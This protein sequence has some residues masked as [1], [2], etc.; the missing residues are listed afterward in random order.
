MLVRFPMQRSGDLPRLSERP[1]AL[2]NAISR[3]FPERASFE[4]REDDVEALR[5]QLRNGHLT[6]SGGQIAFLQTQQEVAELAAWKV[7][8]VLSGQTS[9]VPYR[10]P[11]ALRT[12]GGLLAVQSCTACKVGLEN[13]VSAAA[14]RR[15]S[16]GSHYCAIKLLIVE[17]LVDKRPVLRHQLATFFVRRRSV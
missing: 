16:K 11:A 4:L 8:Q 1:D 5:K 7:R 17:G 12:L 13:W 3:V 15:Y 6:S 9:C 2:N 14:T 10:S